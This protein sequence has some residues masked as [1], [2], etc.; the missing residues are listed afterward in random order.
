MCIHVCLCGVCISLERKMLHK[1]VSFCLGPISLLSIHCRHSQVK[2]CAL[3][4]KIICSQNGFF[5]EQKMKL[6]NSG[7]KLMDSFHGR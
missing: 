3:A 4:D 6:F 2:G 5:Q 1:L 7:V